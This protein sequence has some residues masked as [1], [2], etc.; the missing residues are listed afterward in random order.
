MK[1]FKNIFF[2]EDDDEWK[3]KR[4]RIYY[5]KD[6]FAR[7]VKYKSKIAKACINFAISK[8]YIFNH[9]TRDELEKFEAKYTFKE[10]EK[11]NEYSCSANEAN[12]KFKELYDEAYD[13]YFARTKQK[14]QTKNLR[15]SAVVNINENHTLKDLQELANKIEQK[16][17]IQPIQIVIHRDEGHYLK[18]INGEYLKDENNDFIFDPNLHAHIEF[19]TLDKEGINRYKSKD[20]YKIHKEL[21]T[22]VADE[23]G[24]ERGKDYAMLNERPPQHLNRQEYAKHKAIA[25]RKALKEQYQIQEH[26]FL[27]AELAKLK[28]VNEINKELREQL[29]QNGANRADYAKLEQEVNYY[30]QKIRDREL[31]TKDELDKFKLDYL[32]KL[33]ENMV[34]ITKLE[35]ENKTI[36]EQ[37][38]TLQSQILELNNALNEMKDEFNLNRVRVIQKLP[39]EMKDRLFL[40]NLKR[41]Y[42]YN[43][44]DY[45]FDENQK[46]EFLEV[47]KRYGND[48][49]ECDFTYLFSTKIGEESAY[50]LKHD[51]AQK[52]IEAIN[53]A[54]NN[55]T[56]K[57]LNER[58]DNDTKNLIDKKTIFAKK[59]LELRKAW[60]GNEDSNQKELTAN[61]IDNI[62]N[63]YQ[64][65]RRKANELEQKLQ[66]TNQ[67]NKNYTLSR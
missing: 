13:N 36:K 22:L 59:Y 50:H 52:V 32:N 26:R 5:Q 18:D 20:R 25:E 30:R 2:D 63:A 17:G 1:K 27:K 3:I 45:I 57:E 11:W 29:K 16:Y 49:K 46:K 61:H 60:Y 65:E 4:V 39:Q 28:D 35:N 58:I 8:P 21:Q 56:I 33:D 19:F 24:M 51:K 9:N 31:I 34:K 47:A 43:G 44:G 42:S 40:E 14:I 48:L 55:I 54:T 62:I 64:I 15:V 37:N 41:D 6:N 38:Q 10:F 23:L 66:H 12:V 67:Q 53:L 7:Y